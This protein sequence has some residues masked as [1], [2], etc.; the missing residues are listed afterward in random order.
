MCPASALRPPG[1]A[2]D[3]AVGTAGWR[4]CWTVNSRAC[5][6][7]GAL[8]TGLSWAQGSVV[9]QASRSPPAT[10]GDQ[11]SPVRAGSLWDRLHLGSWPQSPT[12]GGGQ[13]PGERAGPGSSAA[14]LPRH[15]GG[16]QVC[17][18][19][20]VTEAEPRLS[21]CLSVRAVSRG[22]EPGDPLALTSGR[23]RVLSEAAGGARWGHRVPESRCHGQCRVSLTNSFIYLFSFTQQNRIFA[24][25][26]R[27]TWLPPPSALKRGSRPP[28]GPPPRRPR[29]GGRR[30]RSFGKEAPGRG[31]GARPSLWC[32]S[33][34]GHPPSRAQAMRG[35]VLAAPRGQARAARRPRSGL[36]S[37]SGWGRRRRRTSGGRPQPAA[38]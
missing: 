24:F 23:P 18:T 11:R 2:L 3:R 36:T 34:H 13:E 7:K 16:P 10:P 27:Y 32:L 5:K 35:A 29:A 26:S 28:E 1:R 9:P 30:R 15:R 33:K 38:G 14:R 19:A 21:T 25:Q 31:A 22:P 12:N 8:R 4:G 20:P 6:Q 17:V 37:C